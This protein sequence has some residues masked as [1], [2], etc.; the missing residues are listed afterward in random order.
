MITFFVVRVSVGLGDRYFETIASIAD[1]HLSELLDG[2]EQFDND[3]GGGDGEDDIVVV[4]VVVV[5]VEEKFL[6][7]FK[8]LSS[9][10]QATAVAST[11]P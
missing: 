4:C 3:V 2:G 1:K 7:S 6:V 5:V 9:K 8:T 10:S 11:P